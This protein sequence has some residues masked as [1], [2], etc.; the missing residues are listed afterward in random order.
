MKYFPFVGKISGSPSILEG[1]LE[2][3][4]AEEYEYLKLG[5]NGIDFLGY[6]YKA[7]DPEELI[8]GYFAHSKLPTVLAG[9]ISS[10]DRIKFA[11]SVKPWGFT[12]GSALF[13]KKFVKNGT[14]RENLEYVIDILNS[15]SN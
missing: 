11:L 12:M 5:V 9:S 8:R 6:R 1:T 14:F 10:V 13:E 7:S 4:L 15:N 3:M 2:E